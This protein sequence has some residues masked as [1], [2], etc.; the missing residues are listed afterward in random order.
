MLVIALPQMTTPEFYDDDLP[1]LFLG[2]DSPLAL[3]DEE[4]YGD[5]TNYYGLLKTCST[6]STDRHEGGLKRSA[7]NAM[8]LLKYLVCDHVDLKDGEPVNNGIDARTGLP[9]LN[10]F[11][12]A[13]CSLT[14]SQLRLANF[15]AHVMDIR[16]GGND[17]ARSGAKGDACEV[18]VLL[19]TRHFDPND[20]GRE[21]GSEV[22]LRLE[23]VL[24][25]AEA[26]KSFENWMVQ[27]VS[28]DVQNT[29]LKKNNQNVPTQIS[30]KKP[31][32]MEVG[33]STNP[34]G[35][36]VE[37]DLDG[38]F[39]PDTSKKIIEAEASADRQQRLEKIGIKLDVVE[40]DT[41]GPPSCWEDS[42]LAKKQVQ[43][44]VAEGVVSATDGVDNKWSKQI[45][46]RQK[47]IGRDPIG[48]RPD[49]FNLKTIKD[50]VVDILGEGI[51]DL[52]EEIEETGE[53]GKTQEES[54]RKKKDKYAYS[55][56]LLVS[57]QAQKATL[58]AILNGDRNDDEEGVGEEKRPSAAELSILPSD[59]NFDPLLFL[60]IVHG[61]ASY[62]QLKES[63]DKLESECFG[64]KM[65]FVF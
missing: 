7:R 63:A 28:K 12:Y 41:S 8:N 58:E 26:R 14:A 40:K 57:L 18:L 36:D 30:P 64:F 4:Q 49:N 17:G 56:E 3:Y 10:P 42:A 16:S 5:L 43:L 33:Q 15:D 1:L 23:D 24:T 39:K 59:A 45:E 52:N 62:E 31:L 13:F 20:Y 37:V 35:D 51:D 61:N 38:M 29:I 44:S 25:K 50:R 65:H 22:K 11:A 9:E 2:S 32:E 19:F 48:I 60:T 47:L 53:S 54:K 6:P 34:F 46:E 55:V 21:K 27:N